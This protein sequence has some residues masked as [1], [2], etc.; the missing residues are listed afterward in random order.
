MKFIKKLAVVAVLA[1]P[2]AA[3]VE[4]ASGIGSGVTLATRGNLSPEAIRLQSASQKLISLEQQQRNAAQRSRDF[5][6]VGAVIGGTIGAAFGGIACRIDNSCNTTAERNRNIAAGAVVGATGGAVAGKAQADRQNEAAAAE[7]AIRRRLE[8]ASSQLTEAR[9]ARR[10]AQ[11][12]L[13]VHQRKLASLTADVRA[14]R[15]T[16]AELTTARADARAD[17]AQTQRA[18]SALEGSSKSMTSKDASLNRRK[19]QL[20]QELVATSSAH[21][22]L[23]KSISDS[24]L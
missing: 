6:V 20:D 9:N 2:L 8:I 11:A 12:V 21:N 17:A 23:L 15:A 18:V 3:C 22:A 19:S 7:N 24:A 13:R 4:D 10:Q 1:T 16:Q 14:G 5:A